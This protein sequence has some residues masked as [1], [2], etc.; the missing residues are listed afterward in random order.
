M[1]IISSIK[2]DIGK[3]SHYQNKNDEIV[4]APIKNTQSNIQ[5]NKNQHIQNDE[6]TTIYRSILNCDIK[7][8][9]AQLG[10]VGLSKGALEQL[11]DYIMEMVHLAREAFTT[12]ISEE[13]KKQNDIAYQKLNKKVLQELETIKEHSSLQDQEKQN[14]E[15]SFSTK[16]DNI[17]HLI[18]KNL[19]QIEQNT[20]TK[21]NILTKETAQKAETL[22]RQNLTFINNNQNELI[23]IENS[24]HKKREILSSY[25][26]NINNTL[27][28]QGNQNNINRAEKNYSEKNTIDKQLTVELNKFITSHLPIPN[29]NTVENTYS[30]PAIPDRAMLLINKKI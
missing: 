4:S 29:H 20:Q 28:L 25:Q 13:R 15:T 9:E 19:Q 12:R 3:I 10:Y 14:I 26:E 17:F 23:T 16:K 6:Y 1:S 11:R 18:H 22:A 5:T 30:S 21:T 8:V 7:Q 2:Y 27:S 24:L